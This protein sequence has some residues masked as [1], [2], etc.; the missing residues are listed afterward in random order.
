MK[1]HNTYRD[2][3]GTSMSDGNRT[4]RT[5]TIDEIDKL[6]A[7]T[8]IKGVVGILG[9]SERYAR[10]LCTTKAIRAVKMGRNWRVRV[11]SLLEFAGLDQ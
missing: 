11:D 6:G 8:D 2:G 3:K 4:T 5:L 1:S 7:L 10:E 9:C